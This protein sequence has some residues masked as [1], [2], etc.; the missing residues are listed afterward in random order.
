MKRNI[1]KNFSENSHDTCASNDPIVV[2][3]EP[4]VECVNVN[5]DECDDEQDW[6]VHGQEA[7]IN[8]SEDQLVL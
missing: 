1:P 7:N 6:R 8:E 3:Q 5:V 2:A 4:E